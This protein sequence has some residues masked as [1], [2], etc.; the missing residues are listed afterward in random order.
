MRLTQRTSRNSNGP[1]YDPD[2]L[3]VTY[4]D[5]TIADVLNMS[6]E[7]GRKFLRDQATIARKI[8]GLNGLG[9]GYL[10][11]GHLPTILSRGEAQR[12]KLATELGKLK[13]G[14]HSRYP[15]D[16]PTTGLYC[17]DIDWLLINL[18]CRVDAGRSASVI[19]HNLDVIKTGEF[20]KA[21]LQKGGGNSPYGYSSAHPVAPSVCRPC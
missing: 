4:R 12:I 8:S 7:E 18:N 21:G 11:L 2:M 13:R 17:A 14:K 5:R 3:S 1:R 9:L 20:L 15:L 19:E 16:E 10:K 6:L